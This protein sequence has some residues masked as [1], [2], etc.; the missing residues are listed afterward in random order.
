VIFVVLYVIQQTPGQSCKLTFTIVHDAAMLEQRS[1]VIANSDDKTTNDCNS[2]SSSSGSSADLL[3]LNRMMTHPQCR[4][5]T[6]IL[7]S[8][9][10]F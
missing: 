8:I 5:Q 1:I 4:L 10:E 6:L 2:G 3:L 9:G 7:H